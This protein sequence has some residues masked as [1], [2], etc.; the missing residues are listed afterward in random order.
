MSGNLWIPTFIGL[1]QLK[2]GSG[3]PVVV[4]QITNP[5]SIYED[6]VL[7]ENHSDSALLWPAAATPIRPLAC[8]RPYAAG[9]A[10]KRKKKKS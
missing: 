4:Q 5:T 9:T 6:E 3:V 10:I 7:T 8:E 2:L 1:D